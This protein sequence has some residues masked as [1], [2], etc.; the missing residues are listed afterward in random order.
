VKQE[1]IDHIL[2]QV[3]SI[4]G[5]P[6]TSAKLLKMLKDP[7]SSAVQIEDV[8]KY[9][10]GLTANILGLMIGC[11]NGGNGLEAVPS[12]SVTERLGFKPVHLE[13]LAEESRTGVNKL[14]DILLTG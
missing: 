6:A 14:A 9:D 11:G 13:S 5:M 4:P 10:P 7:D 1:K 8:L 3:K 12:N 2:A